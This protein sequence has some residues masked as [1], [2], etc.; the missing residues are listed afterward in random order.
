MQKKIGLLFFWITLTALAGLGIW[1]SDKN[2][3]GR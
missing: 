3:C 2:D 1:L